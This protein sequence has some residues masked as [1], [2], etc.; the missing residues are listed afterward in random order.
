[1]KDDLIDD[2]EDGGCHQRNPEEWT[3]SHIAEHGKADNDGRSDMD[4]EVDQ[5][6]VPFDLGGDHARDNGYRCSGDD[7]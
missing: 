1:M 4:K 2:K 6:G 3:E 5:V 7:H